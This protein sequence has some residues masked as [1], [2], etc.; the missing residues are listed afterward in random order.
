[1]VRRLAERGVA[2]EA[3]THPDLARAR[4]LAG[5]ADSSALVARANAGGTGHRCTERGEGRRRDSQAGRSRPRP[6]GCPTVQGREGPRRRRRF[7]GG[8]GRQTTRRTGRGHPAILDRPV[9]RR[10]SGLRRGV[11]PVRARRR[12]RPQ[13][14]RR[15]RRASTTP[16]IW[17]ARSPP[18]SSTCARSPSTPAAATCGWPA[19]TKGRRTGTLHRIQLISGRPLQALPIGGRRQARSSGGPGGRRCG[20][21]VR[22]RPRRAAPA[23]RP[24]GTATEVVAEAGVRPALSLAL[25]AHDTVAYVSHAGG[26]VRVDLGAAP[27]RRGIQ[28]R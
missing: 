9:R 23:R 12:A 22:A 16:S 4:E 18:A 11:S 24:G 3:L 14:A 28:C 25:A 7:A 15:R 20:T 8:P 1:M 21:R 26:I 19:P 6:L 10:G 17:C 2:T 27:D 5:W 13:A